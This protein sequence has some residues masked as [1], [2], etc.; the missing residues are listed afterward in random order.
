[1]KFNGDVGELG[2]YADMI[3]PD[4]SPDAGDEKYDRSDF[5]GDGSPA[6]L[7]ASGFICSSR[8]L[9]LRDG[10][11]GRGMDLRDV[12][13]R[14]MAARWSGVVGTPGI[15]RTTLPPPLM[16]N[17]GVEGPFDDLYDAG[18]VLCFFKGCFSGVRGVVCEVAVMGAPSSGGG[19]SGRT[20]LFSAKNRI[21]CAVPESKEAV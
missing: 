7:A 11:R 4:E 2:R 13:R 20:C 8:S 1:M 6:S 9:S 17:E 19:V 14:S 15:L 3:D 18:I 16:R 12:A 10:G 21:G 5:A